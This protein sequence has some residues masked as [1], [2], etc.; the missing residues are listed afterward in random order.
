VRT[1]YKYPIFMTDLFYLM[2]PKD[3]KILTVQDQNGVPCIWAE[4]DT[5]NPEVSRE[6]RL[7][8]TGHPIQPTVG[9]R[10]LYIGTFQQFNGTLVF[11][12]YEG[13]DY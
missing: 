2:M 13:V 6:F 8:G 9:K 10:L 1:V 12:L 3:A 5:S 4:V 11:H 7:V